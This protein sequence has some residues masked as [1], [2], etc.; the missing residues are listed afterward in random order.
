VLLV[1]DHP[2][3][4]KVMSRILSRWGLRLT[5]AGRIS[6]ALQAASKEKFDLLISDIGLPD[7]SGCELVEQLHKMQPIQAIALSG[8]GMD[9]DIHRSLAAGFS[10]HLT[11]PV[12]LDQLQEVVT[13]LTEPV[14][15]ANC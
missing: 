3:T 12:N 2:D 15:A 1:D 11:K 6:E 8:F 9:T 5:C 10:A 4:M 7:G 14:N 13:R